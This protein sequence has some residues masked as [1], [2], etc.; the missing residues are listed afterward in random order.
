[1]ARILQTPP[2]P[3]LVHLRSGLYGVPLRR[4]S[5]LVNPLFVRIPQQDFV[6]ILQRANSSQRHVEQ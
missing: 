1:M 3:V 5:L 4:V 2:R 6:V